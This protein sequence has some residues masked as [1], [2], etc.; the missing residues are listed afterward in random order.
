MGG[1]GRRVPVPCAHE[2]PES[3]PIGI[4]RDV[5]VGVVQVRDSERVTVFMREDSVLD[6]PA[7]AAQRADH[8]IPVDLDVSA[9]RAGIIGY[10]WLSEPG[11]IEILVRPDV[12][13]AAAAF[14]AHLGMDD[15]NMVDE[16]VVVS[17]VRDSV[18]TVA[19]E[20]PEV[21]DPI[22]QIQRFL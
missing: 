15:E 22:V 11:V 4:S 14:R 6:H 19:V 21:D 8:G 7:V 2:P 13:A 20:I 18:R 17:G 10:I 3:D 16:A 5:R 1:T 12:G 9:L